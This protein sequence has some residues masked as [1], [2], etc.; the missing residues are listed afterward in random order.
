M[1]ATMQ[2]VVKV[3]TRPG[4]ALREVPI[5]SV[6]PYDALVKIRATSICGTDLHIYHWD[7]WAASR[8]MP[9]LTIGHEFCGTVVEIGSAVSQVKPGDYVSGDSHVVCGT[10][11]QCRTSR[12]HL[13]QNTQIL[14]V[15]RNGCW[16]EYIVLPAAGLWLNP[17]GL[18]PE[19]ASLQDN[20]GNAVHTAFSTQMANRRV[21]VTGCGPVGLMAISVSRAIGAREIFATDLSDYHLSL[22]KQMGA[23]HVYNVSH[24]NMYEA[25]MDQ[26]NG[27]GIDVLLEMSGAAAAMDQGFSVLTLG[28]EVALLGLIPKPLLFDV[29]NHI[30]FK[31]ATVHGVTGRRLWDTWYEMSGLLTS[32]RVDLSPL[33]THRYP[34][35]SFDE[36]LREMSAGH[37]GKVVMYPDPS[38]MPIQANP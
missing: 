33:V 2:A 27:E 21:L 19:Y 1:S 12:A 6:G 15:D 10:C 8:L 35:A 14:G 26:T 36:A 18:A 23:D 11:H 16:A 38:S 17:P 4:M 20:L 32:G 34:L 31:G 25:I 24:E 22:A 13:C 28:G 3:E 5:P 29:N 30:I 37:T 9:P 7:D